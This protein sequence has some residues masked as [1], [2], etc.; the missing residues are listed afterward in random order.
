MSRDL[1]GEIAIVTGAAT[2][3]GAAIARK[4]AERGAVVCAVDLDAEGAERAAAA[5]AAEGLDAWA[6]GADVGDQS[7]VRRVVAQVLQTRGTPS[8]LVNN[9]GI[10][11]PAMVEKMDL[12]AWESVLRVNLTAHFLTINAVAPSMIAAGRGAIVNVSSI[13][14]LRGSVGQVNYA[15]SKAGVIGLTKAAALELARHGIRV[16]AVAPGVVAT[17]MTRTVRET[18]KLR[19]RY[20]DTIPLGRA[21]DPDEVASAVCYLVSAEASYV[22]GDVLVVAGGAHV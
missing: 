3:I 21:A 7:H 12:D 14:G 20:I 5:L 4:L 16:N 9:A 15:A 17:E 22:T 2:G 1:E 18:P 19:E 6:L 11:R 10:T 13:A 8:I